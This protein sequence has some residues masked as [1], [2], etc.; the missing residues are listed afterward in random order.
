MIAQTARPPFLPYAS[1]TRSTIPGSVAE[2]GMQAFDM[3]NLLT[4]HAPAGSAAE[5]YA[6][7]CRIPFQ[8]L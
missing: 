3:C 2:I 1:L 5:Q 4:I 6:E 7:D 8:P